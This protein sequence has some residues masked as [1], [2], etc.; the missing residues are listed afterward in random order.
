[1]SLTLLMM[2]AAVCAAPWSTRAVDRLAWLTPPAA[3]RDS[4]A[5]PGGVLAD[6]RRR[7]AVRA[8]RPADAQ[9]LAQVLDLL[10]VALLAGLSPAD[11]VSATAD[12]VDHHAAEVAAPLR[13][14]AARIRLGATPGE[15]WREIPGS[16]EV[17]PVATALA[18]ATDGGG[19]VRGALEHA[20]TRM[21]AEADAAATARAERAAVLVAGP[22]GLCFLP[23]FICLGV[24]PVVVGLA[25]DMLPGL[26]L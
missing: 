4:P 2:A 5:S 1:M 11:A 9:E 10:A 15:A 19:S 26:A 8:D 17:A 21:R 7:T 25:G 12:A 14:A 6:L 3:A 22:L 13:A 16:A 18:R 23:A 24:L 20:A